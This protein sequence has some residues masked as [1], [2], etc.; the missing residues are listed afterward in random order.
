MNDSGL[1]CGALALISSQ[2]APQQSTRWL[3]SCLLRSSSPPHRYS[4]D[5]ERPCAK[6]SGRSCSSRNL[7]ASLCDY[8]LVGLWTLILHTVKQRS[9]KRAPTC[10]GS[11]QPSRRRQTTAPA[12]SSSPVCSRFLW[13]SLECMH[14]DLTAFARVS[15][16]ARLERLP[17]LHLGSA[18]RW[19]GSALHSF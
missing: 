14:A 15:I 1:E 3:V 18:L 19:C 10:R 13:G 6:V 17:L 16:R 8:Q 4:S 2:P 11:W 12:S 7:Y 9:T 5:H